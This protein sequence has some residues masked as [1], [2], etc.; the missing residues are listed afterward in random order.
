MKWRVI[1]LILNNVIEKVVDFTK[2]NDLISSFMNELKI[3]LE[4]GERSYKKM[5]DDSKLITEFRD[6]LSIQRLNILNEYAKEHE[7]EGELFYVY[8]V[9]SK[10]QNIYNLCSCN[11]GESHNIIEV[12]KNDISTNASVGSILKRDNNYYEIDEEATRE[13]TDKLEELHN[14]IVQEQEEYLKS[15]RIEGHE[16]EVSEKS[17]DRVWLFDIT[18]NGDEAIE[19]INISADLL[20]ELNEG[21]IV[22]FINNEYL[23]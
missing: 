4:K 5:N 11:E 13:I 14:N 10:D 22:K 12:N 6:K 7:N 18:E 8:G 19:E 21:D 3:E 1:L 9:N 17:D 20:N 15:K 16:Y 2:K 23:K